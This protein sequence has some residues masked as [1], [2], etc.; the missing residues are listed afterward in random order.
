MENK[1][2]F[3]KLSAEKIYK[4]QLSYYR[5]A[6]EAGN[7]PWGNDGLP[8]K[9]FV[10]SIKQLSGKL[11]RK[12]ALDLGCGEGRH[13]DF[14]QK[15]GYKVLGL[16]YQKKALANAKGKDKK[17]ILYVRGDIL[18]PPLKKSSFDIV[19]DFGV[20]HHIRRQDTERYL[21]FLTSMI[22]DGGYYLLSCFSTEFTHAN[23]KKYK[24]GF[25]C[26]KNHYDRFSTIP[27]I[28]KIFGER[29]KILNIKKESPRFIDSLMQLK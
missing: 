24:S 15:N 19:I 11:K 20:F 27:Q 18:K 16:E 2:S 23:G 26:H 8:A 3:G 4:N 1:N 21:N 12:R 5:F 6:Y 17:K 7:T 29:F 22:V 10:S 9:T 14:L 28:R 13:S 25:V